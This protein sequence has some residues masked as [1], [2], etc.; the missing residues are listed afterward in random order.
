MALEDQDYNDPSYMWGGGGR[1]PFNFA[2]ANMAANPDRHGALASL[3]TYHGIEPPDE[4]F[5]STPSEGEVRRSLGKAFA[6]ADTDVATDAGKG[7]PHHI[8]DITPAQDF[9]NLGKVLTPNWDTTPRP[10]GHQ[11]RPPSGGLGG[12]QPSPAWAAS[13]VAAPEGN[14]SP[15]APEQT[16]QQSIEGAYP[17]GVEPPRTPGAFGEGIPREQIPDRGPFTLPR[18]DLGAMLRPQRPGPYP[19]EGTGDI[20]V[21]EP[22]RKDE[23]RVGALP[24]TAPIPAHRV[25]TVRVAPTPAPEAAAATGAAPEPDTSEKP[26]NLN[27]PE[28]ASVEDNSHTVLQAAKDAAAAPPEKPD[29][30]QSD[31][32]AKALAGLHAITPNIPQPHITNPPP[33]HPNA[34]WLRSNTAG[35]LLKDIFAASHPSA[36]FRLGEAL[37]GKKFA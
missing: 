27:V 15:Q 22:S 3:M 16:S 2:I 5:R 36:T 11:Q 21:P 13:P 7:S 18:P 37:R 25:K 33:F 26:G 23:S 9:R 24:D 8:P 4:H 17:E 19:A 31:S 14:V 10:P 12:E 28:P 20:N 1:T 29:K 35:D 34:A 30:K 32:L 6:Q